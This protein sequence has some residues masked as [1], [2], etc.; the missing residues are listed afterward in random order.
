VDIHGAPKRPY[1]PAVHWWGLESTTVSKALLGVADTH[2]WED[3]A[4][5]IRYVSKVPTTEVASHSFDNSVR[6]GEKGRRYIQAKRSCRL[7]IDD[8][9]ELCRLLDG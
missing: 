8:E 2:D 6:E 9:L 3:I 5:R 7:Q 1:D 4:R